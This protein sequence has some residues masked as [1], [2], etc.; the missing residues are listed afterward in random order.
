MVTLA[1]GMNDD[2][3]ADVAIIGGG[4]GAV[5]AALAATD[6]GCR[7]ILT[8]E[9]DW[10]G[11]QVTS[12][13]LCVLDELYDPTGET[14]M[15][16]RYAEFRRRTREHYKSRY[17]LSALGAAQLD[18]CAGNSACAP[19]TAEPHVAHAVL[20]EM[21]SGA[22][23]SGKLTILTRHVPVAAEREGDLA[24]SVTCRD[25]NHPDRT[26]TIRAAFF[27]DGTETGDTYPLLKV[28]FNLGSESKAQTGE[29]HADDVA[30]PTA[31]QSFTFC[32]VVEFVPGGKFTGAKPEDYEKLRDG[33][34]F[35]L[36]TPGAKFFELGFDAK[37]FRIVPF[38]FYRCVVDKRNFDDAAVP[39]SRAV[40]NVGSNDYH[41]ESYIDNPRQEEI[42]EEARKLSRAYLYWL[43]T[44]APRD[45]GGVGYPE[46]RPVP[47]ATGTPDGLAQ[48]PYVREG[49]RLRA[50]ETVVEGDL[51]TEQQKQARARQFSNSVGVAAYFVDQHTR[52][53]NKRGRCLMARPYQIPLGALV[54]PELRNFAAAGK[55]IGVT[56]ITNGAYRLHTPEW[57]IGE[58]AGELAAFCLERRIAHPH[59]TGEPLL[60][61]QR[62]L[63][64][65]GIPL[66][67]YEDLAPG[68]PSFEAAQLLALTEIW[69]GHPDHLR[70]DPHQSICRHRPMFLK[71]YE[72]LKAAGKDLTELRDLHV[73]AH[74]ARKHDVVRQIALK[75]DE[76][77]WPEAALG[78][79]FPPPAEGDDSP[80]DAGVLW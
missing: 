6:R 37:G 17:K 76:L 7:V 66:Y 11:G 18:F 14:I 20:L 24:V 16:A 29:P 68:H 50:C 40:I 15:N 79:K 8:D 73:I 46:L 67:W 77:G 32:F 28:P 54:S 30:D 33:Q 23:T 9:F 38:W 43:Q 44:E 56:Q 62:R 64:K 47:E 80:L 63:L 65:Q 74:G 69:P 58:A 25:L 26:R 2:L 49:R 61:F 36:F 21:L 4:F 22:V 41:G 78:R 10:I 70:F 42:L 72:R 57:A 35:K 12:Q 52:S 3:R 39:Y 19:V 45:D 75:L 5:A 71:V 55:G 51:S 1:F 31:I 53:G 59:L 34:P 13:A 27:L 60:E 48:A